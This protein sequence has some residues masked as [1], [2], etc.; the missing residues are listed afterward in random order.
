[1]V[2]EAPLAWSILTNFSRLF[3]WFKIRFSQAYRHWEWRKDNYGL[4]FPL[5][6]KANRQNYAPLR[7]PKRVIV[8]DAVRLY[9]DLMQAH[10]MKDGERL[11]QVACEGL[12]EDMKNR[13]LPTYPT[14]SGLP[15]QVYRWEMTGPVAP[16]LKH[17]QLLETQY[18]YKNKPVVLQQAVVRIISQQKLQIGHVED[19]SQWTVKSP[20]VSSNLMPGQR[21]AIGRQSDVPDRDLVIEE[22]HVK[23]E[24]DPKI[25]QQ[26]DY[27]AIQRR[28]MNGEPGEW[29]IVSFLQ[30]TSLDQF[31]AMSEERLL[32]SMR[33]KG[34]G[35][36]GQPT[37]A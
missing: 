25:K 23:W 10:V 34:G 27:V 2:A 15:T 17:R 33:R 1:M 16:T 5:F 14:A 8:Q 18:K 31:D 19:V 30:P 13:D 7:A 21:G 24:S 26:T 6:H 35:N 29:K 20:R 9:S 28:I 22:S 12:F 37:P 36:D 11:K 3:L 32:E 4:Q